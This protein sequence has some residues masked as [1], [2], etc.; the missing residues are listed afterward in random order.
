MRISARPPP[1][2]VAA[3]SSGCAG[4]LERGGLLA[5]VAQAQARGVRVCHGSEIV[6]QRRGEEGV[7]GTCARSSSCTG[8]LVCAPCFHPSKWR[9][10]SGRAAEPVH[11][12]P[13]FHRTS[14]DAGRCVRT[15]LSPMFP[16]VCHA[17]KN[18]ITLYALQKAKKNKNRRLPLWRSP[19]RRNGRA[20]G[21]R[22][23]NVHTR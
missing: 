20:S 15:R 9:T 7:R 18:S 1:Q 23:A 12:E 13:G 22:T 11:G 3:V 4:G 21:G 16:V 14:H 6:G 2:H 10:C 17:I 5:L 8:S 19:P